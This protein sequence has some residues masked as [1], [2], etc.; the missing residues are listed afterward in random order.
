MQDAVSATAEGK[1]SRRGER[2]L[3]EEG[4]GGL[5]K[6]LGGIGEITGSS[7]R[8]PRATEEQQA[9]AQRS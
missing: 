7:P 6:I 2:A 8:S 1:R 4:A 9:A 5:K 3:A